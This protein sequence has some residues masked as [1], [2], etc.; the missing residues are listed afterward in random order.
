MSARCQVI[1]LAEV[2]GIFFGADSLGMDSGRRPVPICY[3]VTPRGRSQFLT[4]VC[5]KLLYPDPSRCLRAPEKRPRPANREPQPL[6]SPTN[7]SFKK[8]SAEFEINNRH[9][10]YFIQSERSLA[11]AQ[12]SKLPQMLFLAK[13]MKICMCK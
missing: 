4:H 11:N 12:T 3:V 1:S 5:L 10:I 9:D 13:G 6:P 8:D 2:T 7:I